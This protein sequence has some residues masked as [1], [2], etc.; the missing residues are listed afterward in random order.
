[1]TMDDVIFKEVVNTRYYPTT[2]LQKSTV[3]VEDV[4]NSTIFLAELLNAGQVHAAWFC[5]VSLLAFHISASLLL[6][7]IDNR[8]SVLS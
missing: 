8:L 1:M 5:P 7:M 6:F 2:T 3:T 4:V